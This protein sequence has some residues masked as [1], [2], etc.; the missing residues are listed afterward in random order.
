V[1]M[2]PGG[3]TAMSDQALERV[4]TRLLEPA[5]APDKASPRPAN[6]SEPLPAPAPRNKTSRLNLPYYHPRG[7]AEGACPACPEQSRREPAEGEA[8]QITP[9][10]NGLSTV[11]WIAS[12]ACGLLTTTTPGLND[13]R[14]AVARHAHT[15]S[16]G[17]FHKGRG[18]FPNAL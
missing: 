3:W 15:S 8:I 2:T 13:A 12:S 10:A 17:L 5:Q 9:A 7:V 14:G 4:P 6:C 11:F 16:P 1:K 18:E